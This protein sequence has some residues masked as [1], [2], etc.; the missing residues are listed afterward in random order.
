MR[1]SLVR[2]ALW[3]ARQYG[4]LALSSPLAFMA[5]LKPGYERQRWRLGRW[6]AWRVYN[7]AR[8]QVPAYVAFLGARNVRLGWRGLEPDLE[9][10][11]VMDK[12]SYVKKYSIEERCRGGALPLYGAV[13]D[14]SSGT[15]GMP[16]NWVRGP[17]ERQAVSRTLQIAMRHRFGKDPIFCINAFALGPWATGMNVSMSVADIAVLKSTGPEL[18][19][20]R[21]TLK[22]FGPGYR[23]VVMGY[24]PFLKALA[25]S[26][27]IDWAAYDV[28]GIFGG[29]GISEAM[30]GYLQ[31]RFRKVFG[32]YGA[33][34]LEINLAA[35][36]DDTI[37][38]RRLLEAEPRLREEVCRGPPGMLPMVFQYNPL[39]YFIE[40]SPDGEVLVS[41]CRPTNVSPKLRYNIHDTGHVLRMPDLQA[42]LA[43]LGLQDR[44]PTP[45][46]DLPLLFLYGRSDHSVAYYGSKLTPS[47]VEEALYAMPDVAP[48]M[49]GFTLV[50]TED[51]RTDKRLTFAIELAAGQDAAGLDADEVARRLLEALGRA[52][53][54][55]RESLR[56]VPKGLAPAVAFHAAGTGPFAGHDVRNKR[57]YISRGA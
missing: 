17:E 14:E 32:S 55:F 28:T 6:K 49:Q 33:S 4:R 34:D 23:Y 31:Q 38:L 54:D 21:N 19:K 45:A 26:P 2:A 20:I 43:R 50:V 10:I 40:S 25:D 51:D 57:R 44:L 35:E 41:L 37:A 18:E 56:M 48:R 27:D 7:E 1:E 8:V 3:G 15:T 22:L 47:T 39:D 36:N 29:E 52:N 9:S 30:R 16:N 53:Q 42:I 5:M 13:V 46:T 12:D 11:P 24:P